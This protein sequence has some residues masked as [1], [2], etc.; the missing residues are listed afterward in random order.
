MSA[1]AVSQPIRS[2]QIGP[3]GGTHVNSSLPPCPSSPAGPLPQA[4]I[5][6][7]HDLQKKIL[8][9]QRSLGMVPILPAFSGGVPDAMKAKHPTSAFNRHGNWGGF[10]KEYCC[11]LTV[12]PQEPLFSEI[13][14]AFIE[15]VARTL[16]PKPQTPD[17]KP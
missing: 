8:E 17:P 9:R 10:Q 3:K 2:D 1:T 16:N 13:G 14:K 12:D 5:D 15:E 7:Q 11:L 4:W 6:A